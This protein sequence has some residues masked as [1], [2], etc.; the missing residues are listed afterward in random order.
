M[1]VIFAI[2]FL[3]LAIGITAGV[4]YTMISRLRAEISSSKSEALDVSLN[5][6]L[7]SSLRYELE[8]LRNK[9]YNNS[10]QL[11]AKTKDIKTINMSTS[12][13]FI[14]LNDISFN[15]FELVNQLN[16]ST[17]LNY[18]LLQNRISHIENATFGRSRFAPAHSC[19]A[20]H[21]FQPSSI[22]G[23]Y[24]VMSS[25]G[26][27]VRV[28][29]DM[30]KSCGNVTG[31][32]TRVAILNNETRRQLCTDDF[33][34]TNENTRCVR[35][36]DDAGCSNIVFP[37]MNISYSH[38]CGTVQAFWFGFPDG[39]TGSERSSTTINDNYVDGISLTYGTSS[40]VHI[41]TFIADRVGGNQNCPLQVPG[42]VGNDYSCLNNE[43]SCTSNSSSCYSPFFRL[44][45]QPVTE[46]IELRLCR[47]Q[48]RVYS[49]EGIYLGNIE[50][51][52]W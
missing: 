48:H 49:P 50:I 14:S 39:F 40:K 19:Q 7:V 47:D 16:M 22:S 5:E 6:E 32:L 38:I 29:C 51:Y 24:W 27:S 3:T 41:W 21:I 26:S 45:Q 44:L 2:A 12:N 30:T 42:Y 20:I 17:I 35:L 33:T 28:Y 13:A 9:T 10:F 15:L 18:G 34:T 36:T 37:V 46:D 43:I 31:G 23:Y 1:I 4:L 8:L 25:N 52:V 11:S